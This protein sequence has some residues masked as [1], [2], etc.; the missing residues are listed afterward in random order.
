MLLSE[1]KVTFLSLL[2][3]F[4][5]IIVI[6]LDVIAGSLFRAEIFS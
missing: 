6:K 5:E 2:L 1:S 4:T 3:Y